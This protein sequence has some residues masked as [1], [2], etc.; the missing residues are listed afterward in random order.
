MGKFYP[1]NSNVSRQKNSKK[2]PKKMGNGSNLGK[3]DA[4]EDVN[5]FPKNVRFKKKTKN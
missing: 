2:K 4:N 5:N 1:I 3:D